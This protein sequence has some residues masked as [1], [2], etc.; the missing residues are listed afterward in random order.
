MPIQTATTGQLESAQRVII[1][2]TRY[3]AEFEAPCKQ[4]IEHFKLAQG[5]K[6]MTVP[7]VGQMS[8]DN[9]V[10]GQDL[11]TSQ[12]I[13]MTT[14]SLTTGEVGLKVILT[15]KLVR[16]EN[17]DVFRMVGRQMGDGWGR[18]VDR[19]IIALFSALNSGTILGLDNVEL[20]IIQG[21]ALTSWAYA[22]KLPKPI[23]VVH[24]PNA[25][26]TMARATMAV[27]ATYFAG[28]LDETSREIL[29]DF[30]KLNINMVNFY[31]DGNIDKI[32]GYDSGYGAIFSKSAMCFIESAA[33]NTERER[34]ASLRATELV[35]VGDYGVFELD[36]TYG[37]ACQY[38]IGDLVTT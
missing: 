2:Q 36:D 28:I 33:P 25:L 31:Q 7:K 6:S 13:A 24:H 15:D 26:S 35:M 30:F 10:D 19:D 4:L 17:E 18:K 22:H 8:A 3:T 38:E 14:T 27:G 12:D 37:A 21:T 34:D 11:V 9:L 5:E 29:K 16:Q 23:S 32:S 1:A 20:G